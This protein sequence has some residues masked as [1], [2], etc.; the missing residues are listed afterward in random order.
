V[1]DAEGRRI[2]FGKASGRYWGKILSGFTCS[3]GYIIAA[4]TGK[5]RLYTISLP[6]RW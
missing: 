5:S 4:F 2:S 6:V 3:V 1:T